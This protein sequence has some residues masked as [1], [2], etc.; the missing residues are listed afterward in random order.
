MKEKLKAFA[1]WCRKFPEPLQYY[2]LSGPLMEKFDGSQGGGDVGAA[3]MMI[4]MLPLLPFVAIL[5]AIESVFVPF[6]F[7]Q[8][9]YVFVRVWIRDRKTK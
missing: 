5:A 3:I 9:Q 2:P 1:A 6:V 7:I 8:R 4:L